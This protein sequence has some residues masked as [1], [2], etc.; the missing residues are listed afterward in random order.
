MANIGALLLA[1]LLYAALPRAVAAAASTDDGVSA[2]DGDTVQIGGRVFPLFGV[3]AP[4]L[5]QLCF[6]DKKWERCG[7]TAAFELNKLLT[8]DQPLKCESAEAARRRF[9]CHAGR[10]DLAIV[11][12]RAGYA[13]ATPDSG[14]DYRDAERSAREG[15]LGL[16]HMAFLAPW[17]WRA[18]K[19]LP[20][21]P[22]A[23]NA[24][25]PIKGTI[26]ASGRRLYYV[27]TDSA[28]K[29]FRIDPAR[30]ERIFCSVEAA[31]AAG[32]RRPGE[33]VGR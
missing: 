6:H 17:E 13:V 7:V 8:F 9:V 28:F 26:D 31:Q 29:G 21:A 19:R 1:G 2:I 30:D 27:P 20:G 24:E 32:W 5:G 11:L 16:W 4:E 12:L 25:C 10:V 18:G 14:A 23:E 33:A 22:E 15:S 3:D